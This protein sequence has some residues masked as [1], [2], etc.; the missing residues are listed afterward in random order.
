MRKGPTGDVAGIPGVVLLL[1]GDAQ[2][3]SYVLRLVA[4]LFAFEAA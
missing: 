3:L 1:S 4:Q 2:Q